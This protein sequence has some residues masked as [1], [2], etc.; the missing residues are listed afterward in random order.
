MDTQGIQETPSH[1]QSSRDGQGNN[2]P[3]E[4]FVFTVASQPF[5][6]PQQDYCRENGT[7]S[8]LGAHSQGPP[9]D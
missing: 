5:Q 1:G 3:V 9:L 6:P 8:Y 7:D 2:E 4:L